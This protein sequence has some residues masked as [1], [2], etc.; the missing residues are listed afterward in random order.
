MIDTIISYTVGIAVKIIGL[1]LSV[2]IIFLSGVLVLLVM[3]MD[4]LYEKFD[5]WL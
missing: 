2:V 3:I 1:A 4:T 5:K